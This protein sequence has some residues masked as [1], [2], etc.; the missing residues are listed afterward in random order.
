MVFYLLEIVENL[1]VEKE[2]GS[3]AI[4]YTKP[5]NFSYSRWENQA[6][7]YE[8][9]KRIILQKATSYLDEITRL[10]SFELTNPEIIKLKNKIAYLSN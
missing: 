1:Q 5:S 6:V 4:E 2:D 9:F 10:N 8:I 7:K 3:K